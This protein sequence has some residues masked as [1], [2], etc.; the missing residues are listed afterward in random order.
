MADQTN[1]TDQ[2]LKEA[3]K[4]DG[5]VVVRNIIEDHDLEPIREHIKTKVDQYACEQYAEGH[6]SSLYETDSFVR[7][8]AAICQE[9]SISPRGWM[10]NT[11]GREFYNLYN[12]PGVLHVLSIIPVSYTHLTLPTILHV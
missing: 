10:G 9:L 4:K 3:F 1:L 6:I 2:E 5:Y 7:R 8:Y 11:Y 12:L